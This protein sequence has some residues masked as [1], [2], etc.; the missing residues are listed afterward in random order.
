MND[1]VNEKSEER[2]DPFVAAKRELRRI[3]NHF[4]LRLREIQS[5]KNSNYSPLSLGRAGRVLPDCGMPDL[6]IEMAVT[7]LVDK[8]LQK[9]HPFSLV[10][11]VNM[12]EELHDLIMIFQSKTRVGSKVILTSLEHNA[13]NILIAIELNREKPD[14]Q[15][16]SIRSVYPKDNFRDILRWVVEDGL[17]EYADKE[18]AFKWLGKQQSYSADVTRLLEGSLKIIQNGN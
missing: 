18:K 6:P 1:R 15:F 9:T 12:P 3:N 13:I 2:V 11:L 17:L 8:K 4:N 10:A 14:K 7:R 5:G 16:N